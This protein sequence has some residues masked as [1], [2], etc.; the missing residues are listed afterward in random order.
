MAEF[1]EI[2]SLEVAPDADVKRT[3]RSRRLIGL[4][5]V[6]FFA[7]LVGGVLY[8]Y[9]R[10]W[11]DAEA[12]FAD[13]LNGVDHETILEDI[14][15]SAEDWVRFEFR[16]THVAGV[17]L[18]DDRGNYLPATWMMSMAAT[19]DVS[20]TLREYGIVLDSWAN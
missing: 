19:M 9:A 15:F 8:V 18:T 2:D 20:W 1:E 17:K 6:L 14:S 13:Q 12:F 3:K 11:S 10:A 4:W 7:L 16:L 5:I